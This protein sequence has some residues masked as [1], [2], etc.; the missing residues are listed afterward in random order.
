[1]E[2]ATSASIFSQ[3][4]LPALP[5]LLTALLLAVLLPLAVVIGH[6]AGRRRRANLIAAGRDSDTGGDTSLGAILA[7]LGLLL[8]FTFGNALSVS[9]ASRNAI[10]DEAAALGTAFLRADYL[11]DPG[12]TALQAALLDYAKTRVT[13]GSATIDTLEKAQAFLDVSLRAQARLWPLTVAATAD[14]VPPPIQAFVATAVNQ[15]ID[16]H[17][18]RMQTFSVPVS[19][20]A[21]VMMLVAAVTALFL[22][23]STTGVDGR[24]LTTRTF[25][26][27]G[28][29]FVVMITI[30]DT[31]RGTEG[32]I[33]VDDSPLRA[34]IFDMEQALDGRI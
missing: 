28:I 14:P 9:Q 6:I 8:A 33:R 21:Y 22:I 15:A 34:T 2:T 32:L 17:L 31:Q 16:A 13:P 27:A 29:L 20:V 4:T 26:F 19:E 12:R 23:G 3:I 7:L 11:P 5:I 30:I 10:T 18:Y 24:P 1:M 25:V